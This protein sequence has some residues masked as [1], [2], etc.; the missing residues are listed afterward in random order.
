[1]LG[2]KLAGFAPDVVL[3]FVGRVMAVRYHLT[4]A[5]RL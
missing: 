5:V 1:M 3:E 4:K 2:W